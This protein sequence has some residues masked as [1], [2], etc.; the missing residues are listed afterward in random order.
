MSQCQEYTWAPASAPNRVKL[1]LKQGEGSQLC[2]YNRQRI[3]SPRY[4][5]AQASRIANHASITIE[6]AIA[7]S[8]EPYLSATEPHQDHVGQR[9]A[10]CVSIKVYNVIHLYVHK[11]QLHANACIK[12]NTTYINAIRTYIQAFMHKYICTCPHSI[13]RHTH[14]IHA[15]TYAHYQPVIS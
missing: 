5:R 13:H 14:E 3:V 8:V 12:I 11:Y 10:L 9:L 15:R 4:V 2:E 7:G 6:R 1:M